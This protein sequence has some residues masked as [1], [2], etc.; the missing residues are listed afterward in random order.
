M[1]KFTLILIS[2]LICGRIFGGDIMALTLRNT[3]DIAMKNNLDILQAE[4]NAASAEAQL[5]A[6]WAQ[7]WIPSINLSGQF[8]YIDPQTASRGIFNSYSGG[9]PVTIT[10]TF[11]DNYTSSLS[12]T[13]PLF[14][15]LKS[16]NSMITQ[17]LNL[18]L[19]KKTLGDARR[20]AELA[21]V[22]NFY[23]LF[24]LHENVMLYEEM[25]SYF[26]G[27]VSNAEAS[28]KQGLI[29]ELDYLKAILPY[30]NNLPLFLKAKH[31]EISVKAALCDLMNISNYNSVEFIGN[32][33]D[34]TNFNSESTNEAEFYGFALSN[35]IM[36]ST[37][38]YNIDSAKLM[39]QSSELSRL[40]S[41]NLG[42]TYTEDFLKTNS[43]VNNTRNWTPGWTLDL[44]LSMPIDD[45]LP[46]SV[47]SKTIES[48]DENIKKL[49]F[50]RQEQ[51]NSLRETVKS[52]VQQI[53]ELKET[54]DGLRDSL[55]I[56]DKSLALT[57]LQ[58]QRHS[59]TGLD[60][61]N[62][63]INYNQALL[64]YYQS[65]FAYISA[66]LQLEKASGLDF[67][68]NVIEKDRI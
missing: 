10:N 1:F 19:M 53:E 8:D 14:D 67:Y 30:K 2:V 15:G 66:E 9:Q 33:L 51:A 17:E 24:L 50:S 7:V 31:N 62:A 68:S 11:E 40:P 52:Y 54:S 4:K 27:V 39:K 12:L 57:K 13:K 36:I 49:E 46:F 43:A 59:L 16:W 45:L 56:A 28:Y 63:Q 38:I 47:L 65:L 60:L 41:I 44:Q 29:S 32:F 22:T 6:G 5:G 42:Y 34:F 61:Q 18:S 37:I 64:A 26:S 20:A 21:V 23:N 35:D 58:Y 55:V 25:D 48:M 3:V